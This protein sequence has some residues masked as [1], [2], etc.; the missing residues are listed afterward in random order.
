MQS[1]LA[2]LSADSR[3]VLAEGSGH[4]VHLDQPAFVV[5]AIRELV[6]RVR[7][8]PAPPP[9]PPPVLPGAP[10]GQRLPPGGTGAP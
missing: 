4:Y 10:P 7:S 5:E 2:A 9:A 6:A 1:E 3:H 8:R